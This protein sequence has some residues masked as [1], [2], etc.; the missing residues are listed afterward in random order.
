MIIHKGKENQ[1]FQLESFKNGSFQMIFMLRLLMIVK[2]LNSTV[3]QG[4][5]ADI[6]KE[7]RTQ[8]LKEVV[9]NGIENYAD[10]LATYIYKRN[11]SKHVKVGALHENLLN[12]L[13]GR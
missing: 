3:C 1:L 13:L 5:L 8:N 10:G 2:I 4:H 6:R 12:Y 11:I 9:I 7:V